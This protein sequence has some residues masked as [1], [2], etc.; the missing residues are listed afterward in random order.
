MAKIEEGGVL[1]QSICNWMNIGQLGLAISLL[2]WLSINRLNW[3]QE[4]LLI[5][6]WNICQRTIQVMING[7][8][9]WKFLSTK[10]P[11][12]KSNTYYCLNK[13]ESYNSFLIDLYFHKL[14]VVQ[15][16]FML[17]YKLSTFHIPKTVIASIHD[18]S[19]DR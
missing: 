18:I 8:Q 3:Y 12:I 15:K 19:N 5:W 6:N 13:K 14:K 17:Q 9:V 11:F 16:F 7:F 4:G 10:F 1:T 2:T